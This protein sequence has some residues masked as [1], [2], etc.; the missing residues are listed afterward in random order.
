MSNVYASSYTSSSTYGVGTSLNEI[1][2]G[3]IYDLDYGYD[4]VY[5]RESQYVYRLAYSDDLSYSDG[6]FSGSVTL[7]TYTS[8]SGSGSSSSAPT[9]VI[10]SDSDFYL[11]VSSCLVYSSISGFPDL[12]DSSGGYYVQ[13]IAVI[14]SSFLLL[15]VFF[16]IRSAFN[17][18]YLC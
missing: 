16:R 14:L 18:K 13:V 11:S 7:V 8:Y 6:V 9:V 15:F 1:F 4:Y 10:S 3:Y 12:V 2:A 17:S 5:W